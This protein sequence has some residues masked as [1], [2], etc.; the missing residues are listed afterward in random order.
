MHVARDAAAVRPPGVA[1]SSKLLSK[2]YY[3]FV[4]L[5]CAPRA[6][7]PRGT[8]VC[9][10]RKSEGTAVCV[11]PGTRTRGWSTCSVECLGLPEQRRRDH[12]R[13]QR[14]GLLQRGAPPRAPAAQA[15]QAAAGHQNSV[16]YKNCTRR[17][18]LPTAH[19]RAH[20]RGSSGGMRRRETV[21]PT[22]RA[23]TRSTWPQPRP[24]N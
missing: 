16:N 20:A 22:R 17:R 18:R 9:E 11:R 12:C 2:P 10:D 7:A 5:S 13:H 4:V 23:T 6:R 3:V 24:C 21:V 14:L 19:T 15:R 1:C 8:H